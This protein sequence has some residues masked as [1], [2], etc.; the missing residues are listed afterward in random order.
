MKRGWSEATFLDVVTDASRG[1]TKTAQKDYLPAG[2]LPIVD[3]G[4]DA[5]G[6]WSNDWMSKSPV[7]LPVVVFGDHTRCVK[8]VDFPFGVGA[9]GTKV[10]KPKA[11]LDTRFLFHWMR[12]I[13]L[14]D[15]GYSRHFKFLKDR[16]V[17]LPPL[18]EQRRI[19]AVLDQADL[20]RTKRRQALAK[21][22]TLTQAIFH[23][24]FGGGKLS[25]VVPGPT[26]L[27]HPA[28]WRWTRL[29]DVA[30]MGTGHTPDRKIDHYWGGTVGWIN[31]TEIR[32]LDGKQCWN[33]EATITPEGVA[34]S[35]AVVH[36]IGTVCF[37]RTASIGFV[38]MMA[39][40]MTTSQDFVTWTCGEEL[41][42]EYLMRALMLSREVLRATSSGSTHRTI[43]VRDAERFTVL[44]PPRELQ[45]EF[46]ERSR[47]V[48]RGVEP[49]SQTVR[50]LD[51]LF[52]SLQ[53]R[54]FRG[55]L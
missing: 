29:L 36:P 27:Q 6:G 18:E 21:L 15:A 19:A 3:Q 31:L 10:L 55:E 26:D 46:A 50:Q 39:E 38:T 25:P 20:L 5:I 48:D 44:L 40:P 42:P 34:K 45:D 54:A 23:D 11:G 28:G 17:P 33:T 43:Y 14:R 49:I 12:S 9:D 2:V 32:D 52:A 41:N 24:M 37:S 53:Q 16:V 47:R 4:R 7:D 22:D 51:T 8:F 1:H 30:T 35:S 13:D